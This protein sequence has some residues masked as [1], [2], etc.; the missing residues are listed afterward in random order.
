[1]ANYF[2]I[3]LP[4]DFLQIKNIEGIRLFIYICDKKIKKKKFNFE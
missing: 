1:M 2:M 4:D 3:G